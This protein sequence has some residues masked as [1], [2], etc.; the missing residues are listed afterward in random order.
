[1]DKG[2]NNSN[3]TEVG[4]G[5]ENN[6]ESKP[7]VRTFHSIIKPNKLSL[8][9]MVKIFV[10]DEW[11][12]SVNQIVNYN[13]NVDPINRK[14]QILCDDFIFPYSDKDIKAF[15]IKALR[16]IND[17]VKKGDLGGYIEKEENLSIFNES[18]VYDNS[19]VFEDAK[20][21]DDA[22][23]KENSRVF[24]WANIRNFATVKGGSTVYGGVVLCDHV[25][26]ENNITLNQLTCFSGNSII[27]DERD[28]FYFSPCRNSTN[29]FFISYVAN[30]DIWTYL[31]QDVPIPFTTEGFK[32]YISKNDVNVEYLLSIINVD[33][34]KEGTCAG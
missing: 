34:N 11:F 8:D 3:L 20:V 9:E 31:I 12:K 5:E 32:T 18:W 23:V 28:V 19:C 24:G 17:D 26:V 2:T 16:N 1:M 15:R 21:E 14:Y 27:K 10:E 29:S 22:K 4:L 25:V 7:I 6:A 33:I 30:S 13:V